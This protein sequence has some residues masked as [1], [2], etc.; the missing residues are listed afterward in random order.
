MRRVVLAIYPINDMKRRA[1]ELE[2]NARSKHRKARKENREL[3]EQEAQQID[4]WFDEVD[5]LNEQIKREERLEGIDTRSRII[6]YADTDGDDDDPEIPIRNVPMH[7]ADDEDREDR[8][9]SSAA[10]LTRDYFD[11]YEMRGDGF[12]GRWEDPRESERFRDAY[13]RD[14]SISGQ[15]EFLRASQSDEYNEAF[16]RAMR[17]RGFRTSHRQTLE[18]VR[19]MIEGVDEAGGYLAPTQLVGGIQFEAQV[20]EELKPRMD[21]LRASARSIT[22]TKGTDSV[23]MGWVPE[24]GTKPE[25]Q[26]AFAQVNL[27][28]H[29]A[30]VVIWFSDELLEDETYG[31]QSYMQTRVGEAKT[32]LEEEA[33]ISGSG[34]GRP[35]GLLT[36]LNALDNTPYQFETDGQALTADDIIGLPYE[37]PVQYRRRGVWILGTNAI[38]AV[39]LQR[40]DSG[41]SAGTGGYIWQPS[42]QAGEPAALD[43]KPVIETTS[44]A[45]NSS[46][47]T[48]NDV[49]IFGDLRQY[50]VYERLGLQVKRLE[51]LRALTDE[52]GFRFRFRTGG[53][54]MLEEAFRTIRIGS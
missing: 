17:G 9:D 23:V 8:E 18:N 15:R 24:L 13:L 10:D 38:R 49:G 27:T 50:R 35:A 40:D 34:I 2:E 25:D 33:F 39:R 20:L 3:T 16:Y 6:D 37:M 44:V 1:R 45:L 48:G 32:L 7:R 52:V 43:G 28:A 4:G 12:M 30:A 11:P 31:V 36:R 47:A 29:V 51:E 14:M 5:E 42:L 41:A 54:V 26:L 22:F 19:T 53:D 21:I 46:I